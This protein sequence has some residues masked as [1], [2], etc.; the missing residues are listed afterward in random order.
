MG[1]KTF[2]GRLLFPRPSN[3]HGAG[4]GMHKRNHYLTML[5]LEVVGEIHRNKQKNSN[6]GR[7]KW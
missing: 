5:T 3:C 4:K 2:I 7:E 1:K 6:L